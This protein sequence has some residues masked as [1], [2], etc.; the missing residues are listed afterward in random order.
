MELNKMAA[1]ILVAG[2][3]ALAVGKVTDILYHPAEAEVRGY[4]IAVAETGGAAKKAVAK[5]PVDITPFLAS[6]DPAA[7]EAM[8]RACVTCHS[9]DEGGPHKSGP[10]LYNIV[11]AQKG[12][13]DGFKYSKA[14]VEK[15]G[16]WG[17]QELSEFLTKPKKY[18]KGTRMAYAGI[19]K[20]EA[21]ANLIAYLNTL[22]ASPQ[23]LPKAE[24]EAEEEAAPEMPESP[25]SPEAD[26]AE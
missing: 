1:A 25:A 8:I 22:S 14:M 6:A 24:P 17:F 26:D 4:S 16:V 3:I 11:G 19:K 15:G 23:P 5:G 12:G 9:F 7:G 20:P 21:R 10:N 18:I 2:L 13:K